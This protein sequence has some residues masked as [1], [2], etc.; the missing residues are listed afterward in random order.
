VVGDPKI[1]RLAKLMRQTN[2]AT[3]ADNFEMLD[4]LAAAASLGGR[5]LEVLV[6]CDTG[7]GRNGVQTPAA[8]VA[9]AQ[10][11]SKNP[12]LSLGGLMT[13]PPAFKRLDVAHFI[14]SAKDGLQKAG[15]P[16]PR[17]SSGGSK[18]LWDKDGLSEVSE[19]RAGTYIYNDRQMLAA[20]ACSASGCAEHVLATVI[21]VP[22]AARAIIDAGSKALTSDQQGLEG[23]GLVAGLDNAVVY[24]VNEE[25]GYLDIRSTRQKVHVGDR[26]KVLMNHTCP[27]N[28]LFDKVVFV[29]G[30]EVL[31]AVR[32]DARGKVH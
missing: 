4:G 25:H 6:E 32:V 14:A 7:M 21:S 23:F 8:A 28:N 1:R 27:V 16:C 19:Y 2:I 24:N 3:V 15:L 29:S 20:G 26:V 12:H 13:Y 18:D 11:I 22:T 10:A 31:G 5:K 30:D 17:V 9:L